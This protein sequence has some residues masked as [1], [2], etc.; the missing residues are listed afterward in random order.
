[1]VESALGMQLCEEQLQ[2]WPPM[3][4]AGGSW[5]RS[6]SG[7]A[8]FFPRMRPTSDEVVFPPEG[9]IVLCRTHVPSR[10]V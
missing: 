9:E 1:M 8:E 6:S 2:E 4:F 7:M 3:G 10:V 5:P